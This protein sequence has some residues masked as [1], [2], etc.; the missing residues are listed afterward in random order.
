MLKTLTARYNQKAML[1]KARLRA[2]VSRWVYSNSQYIQRNMQRALFFPSLV[3]VLVIQWGKR[4]SEFTYHLRT[5][6]IARF[7]RWL[8]NNLERHNKT[9][10]KVK[11]IFK[12]TFLN[13]KNTRKKAWNSYII[14]VQMCFR[15]LPS[16]INLMCLLKVDHHWSCWN[17]RPWRCMATCRH[18]T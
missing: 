5:G 7:A 17:V 4:Q 12:L 2:V 14:H 8:S 10:A 9:E 11:N 1:R 15:T 18:S 16:M 6:G 3:L 13:H